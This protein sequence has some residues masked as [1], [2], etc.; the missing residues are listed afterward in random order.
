MRLPRALQLAGGGR[1]SRSAAE[2]LFRLR[3]EAA[4]VALWLAPPS[5]PGGLEPGGL[6]LPP[7]DE[8]RSLVRG[9]AYQERLHGDALRIAGGELP[10]FGE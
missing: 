5:W 10:A 3:Q 7:M 6:P 8:I 9:T 2:I 4:N 1:L